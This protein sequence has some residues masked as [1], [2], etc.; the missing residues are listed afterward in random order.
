[1]P[2]SRSSSHVNRGQV[3]APT[4]TSCFRTCG[5]K[6]QLLNANMVSLLV[7]F[8]MTFFSLVTANPITERIASYNDIPDATFI[9]THEG[10]DYTL[11]GT[12][13]KVIA[14]MDVLHPGYLANFTAKV[15]G[16]R[17][18][19]PAIRAELEPRNQVFPPL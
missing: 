15:N 19:H 7:F 1:V 6:M 4:P 10:R 8:I 9:I 17:S 16:Y 5:I 18:N 2:A 3:P 14:Q 13:Q 12:A 11:Q